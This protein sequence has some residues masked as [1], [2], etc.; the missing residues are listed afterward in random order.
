MNTTLRIDSEF[1]SLCP[2]LTDEE[3]AQLKENILAEGE[4]LTPIIVWDGVIIDGHNRYEI[5]QEHPEVNYSTR[6]KQ[7]TNRHEAIA[8]ICRNQLGR[9]NLSEMQKTVLMGRRYDA[10]K[11]AYGDRRIEAF[12]KDHDDRLKSSSNVTAQRLA[13]EL[14]V[15]EATVRRASSVVAGLDAAEEVL[16]GVAREILDGTIKPTKKEVIAVAKAAPEER[17]QRAEK[18][19][20]PKETPKKSR[21]ERHQ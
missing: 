2:P 19:R 15:S 6:E 9:R 18:L 3:Y 1:E 12:S 13:R 8:W 11:L 16:P 4:V 7:F 14:G 17:R 20:V 10:E 21:A 5:L